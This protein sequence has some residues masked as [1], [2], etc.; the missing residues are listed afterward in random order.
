MSDESVPQTMYHYITI[1]P[2]VKVCASEEKTC[3]QVSNKT[4][5]TT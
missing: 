5:D 1:D 4:H 3:Q 2:V